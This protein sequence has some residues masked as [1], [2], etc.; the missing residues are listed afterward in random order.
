MRQ[1]IQRFWLRAT[2]GAI[3]LLTLFAGLA[4]L[5]GPV[6]AQDDRYDYIVVGSGA[7]GGPLAANLARRG[8][9]VLLLE[10]GLDDVFQRPDYFIPIFTAA[11]SPENPLTLWEY[12]VKHYSDEA[13]ARRDTKFQVGADGSPLGIFYPRAATLGGSVV[14]NF[15]FAVTP[16]DSDWEQIAQLTGDQTWRAANMR[17]YFQRLEANNYSPII[18]TGAGHGFNGW[19]GMQIFDPNFFLN[20]DPMITRLL[21]AA[22]LMFPQPSE[23]ALMASLTGNHQA[24]LSLLTRDLNSGTA[25]RDATEGLFSPTLHMRNG[26]RVTPREFIVETV[27]QGYP[28]TVRTGAFVTKILFNQ[29]NNRLGPR[30]RGVEYIDRAHVYQADPNVRPVDATVPRRTARVR[31]EVIISAGTF[32]TPQLLMLSGVGPA[33]ELRR[34][35]I[36]VL[37]NSPGVGRNLQDRY[38]IGVVTELSADFPMLTPCTFGQTPDDPCLA[39]YFQGTGLYNTVGTVGVVIK[40]SSTAGPNED[41]D[42][43]LFGAPY[44]FRGYFKGYTGRV[45]PNAHTFTWGVLKG[46]TR[47][48]AGTVTLRSANPLERPEINFRYFHEGTTGGADVADLE[49]VVDGVELIRRIIAK[50]N[51][52][53]APGTVREIFPGPEVQTR[54]QIRTFVRN[55]AWGHHASGTAA[56]GRDGD[57][58]A[59]LD[60]KFRVRGTRGLRV[61]DASIFP[62]IPGFFIVVPIF[63]A[64]EKAADV[65]LEDRR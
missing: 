41:P 56:M 8:Q 28:L 25:G 7:G 52:L 47:N 39:Q 50:S 10:A 13:Q 63:M 40:K 6:L 17:K 12:Y 11:V 37:V 57:P 5:N 33:E 62:R 1:S 30:A 18:Q 20:N 58:M 31:R 43:L 26:R 60:S 46:H 29:T 49:A 38:E 42:L 16:H 15:L 24:L 23:A 22:A 34:L 53:M 21:V 65:I 54:D 45:T 59:V 55:N 51:E 4:S 61:V 48:R 27:Q 35:N 3:C 32:N 2:L 9:R 44:D 19:L 64:S 36:P 14:H